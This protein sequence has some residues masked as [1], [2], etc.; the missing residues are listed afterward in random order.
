MDILKGNKDKLTVGLFL[1][2][3]TTLLDSLVDSWFGGFLL[4]VVSCTVIGYFIIARDERGER[5]LLPDRLGRGYRWAILLLLSPLLFWGLAFPNYNPFRGEAPEFEIMNPLVHPDSALIIGSADLS[6]AQYPTL[7]VQLDGVPFENGAKSVNIQGRSY[8]SFA[9]DGEQR[10]EYL[11][12]EGLH[13]V[14]VAVDGDYMSKEFNVVLDASLKTSYFASGNARADT[15]QSEIS[16]RY[17]EVQLHEGWNLIAYPLSDAFPVERVFGSIAG[18][19]LIVRDQDGDL[20]YPSQRVATIGNLKPGSGLMVF[21]DSSTVLSF[22]DKGQRLSPNYKVDLQKGWN[23]IG[24]HI[25]DPMAVEEAFASIRQELT[26]VKDQAGN[27]YMPGSRAN[28]I[29]QLKPLQGYK[30]YVSEPVSFSFGS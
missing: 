22:R 24:Y 16:T 8:W 9:P 19:S 14:R 10:S 27:L 23:L 1:L 26:V 30:V 2:L 12:N 7:D 4:A 28:S 29:G 18:R 13:V 21:V 11:F 3:A 20:Y 17:F 5:I 15:L 25:S 6:P